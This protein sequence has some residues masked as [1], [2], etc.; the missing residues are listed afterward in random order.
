MEFSALNRGKKYFPKVFTRLRREPCKT[1][2]CITLM[3]RL[4]RCSHFEKKKTEERA[5]KNLISNYPCNVIPRCSSQHNKL[6]FIINRI[7]K[8]HKAYYCLHYNLNNWI[9]QPKHR[10]YTFRPATIVSCSF[11]VVPHAT[12][13]KQQRNLCLSLNLWKAMSIN[14]PAFQRSTKQLHSHAFHTEI[15]AK[16]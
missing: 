4:G 7:W 9:F 15:Y 16:G 5:M 10:S 6:V 11:K 13:T 1:A 2:V 12:A 14:I 3:Q 8:L